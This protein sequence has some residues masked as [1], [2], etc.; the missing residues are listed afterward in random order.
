[1]YEHD[2]IKFMIV[3]KP[4]FLRCTPGRWI[5]PETSAPQVVSLNAVKIDHFMSSHV[6]SF[7]ST[8][9]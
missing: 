7:R 1:M 5:V 8:S 6:V 3:N 2:E 9:S 4:P